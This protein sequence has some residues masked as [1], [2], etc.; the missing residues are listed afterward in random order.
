VDDAAT[1]L[2][3]LLAQQPTAREVLVAGFSFGA[4]IGLRFGCAEPR[5]ARLIAI[6]TPGRWLSAATL[7]ACDKPIDFIHGAND[8]VAALADLEAVLAAATR[9]A[10]TRLHVV[11]DADHFFD[12][13]LDELNR[14]VAALVA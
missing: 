9:R 3:W 2:A 13:S 7:A 8:Q 1:A 10:P 14:I 6:G 11:P 12:G 5:V 4:S